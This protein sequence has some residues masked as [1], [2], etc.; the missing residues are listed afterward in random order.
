VGE[1]LGVRGKLRSPPPS[2]LLFLCQKR[3]KHAPIILNVILSLFG[4]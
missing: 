2:Y 3:T 4:L 1:G